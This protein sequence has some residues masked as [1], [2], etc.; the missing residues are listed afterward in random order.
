MERGQFHRRTLLLANRAGR[1]WLAVNYL[2]SYVYVRAEQVLGALNAYDKDLLCE[3]HY[4][5]FKCF[6]SDQ[7]TTDAELC[8]PLSKRLQGEWDIQRLWLRNLYSVLDH[9]NICGIEISPCF[10]W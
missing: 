5:L 1:T 3:Y 4:R 7:R 6:E 8:V 2:I 9:G 10:T